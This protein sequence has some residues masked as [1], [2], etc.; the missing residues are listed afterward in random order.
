[1]RLVDFGVCVQGNPKEKKPPTSRDL[2]GTVPYMAPELK[3]NQER[4]L[5]PYG[6]AVDWYAFGVLMYQL[7]EDGQFPFGPD[8]DFED[9]GAE[10]RQP[11]LIGDDGVTEV[12]DLYDLLSGLLDWNPK[13]RYG[14]DEAGVEGL[15]ANPYWKEPDWELLEK[16]RIASP[17][18]PLVMARSAKR[19]AAT[20]QTGPVKATGRRASLGHANMGPRNSVMASGAALELAQKLGAD[21]KN[22][23][24]AEAYAENADSFNNKKQNAEAAKLEA[25][26]MEMQVEGWEYVSPH[27]I[28]EEYVEMAKAVVSIV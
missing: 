1:M 5:P 23:D 6:A 2:C 11:E 18:L 12:P 7:T 3:F 14:A 26:Q 17:L 4:G 8:P 28:A 21:Q 19:L 16:R 9:M 13:S 15:K 20:S 10:F 25:M 24:K 22:V 27:A